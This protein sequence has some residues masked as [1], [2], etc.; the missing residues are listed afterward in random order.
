[1]LGLGAVAVPLNPQSPPP[2]LERELAH[3]GAKAVLI[4]PG[5]G[6]SWAGVDRAERAR[7]VAVVVS[8]EPAR[9][10]RRVG[11]ACPAEPAVPVVDVEPDDLAVL[12]FTSGTAGH[13]QAAMLSHGNLLA[14]LE[15][16]LAGGDP[17]GP[18]RRRVRRAADVPHLRAERRARPHPARR[19]ERRAGPAVRPGDGPRHHRASAA[20]RSCPAR[21]RMWVAWSSLDDGRPG[22]LRQRAPGADGRGEDARGGAGARSRSASASQLREGYGLTEASPVVTV[23]RRHRRRRSGSIG[24]ARRTASRCASSTPTA[25]TCSS[26]T[27]ARSGC[28][29]R[30]CSRATG[31]I[32]RRRRGCSPPTAGCAPATS[33]W[34]TTTATCSSST[35]PRTSS[36]CRAS[37]CTR[38]R[39]RR[40]SPSSPAWPRWRSSACPTPTRGEAVKAYVVLDAGRRPRRGARSSSGASEHLA[41]YKCPSKVLFVD[42]LPRGMGGKVLRRVLR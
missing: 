35:G 33:P 25:T 4:G 20:S 30:T 21:R 24:G 27:P 8:A 15:Q 41:R 1:M 13:P 3:V 36:S 19:C 22:R 31:T 9:R 40:S 12:M 23:E 39:S 16:M 14:N 28:G 29:A 11:R 17:P 7:A 10:R 34:S 6:P 2:E 37:T 26:A 18:R 38:P 5:P 32:P 42:E